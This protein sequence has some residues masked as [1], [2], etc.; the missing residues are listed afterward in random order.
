MKKTKEKTSKRV[1]IVVIV[2]V[3]LF[4][5]GIG[6]FIFF[7]F[8]NPLGDTR[9]SES[10][11]KQVAEITQIMK[12]CDECIDAF[13]KVPTKGGPEITSCGTF[14]T[15]YNWSLEC[16]TFFENKPRTVS[17]CGG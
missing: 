9:L 3:I 8:V 2:A 5:V 7:M 11:G 10:A 4:I 12:C 13:N 17:E 14:T 15:S 1:W 16:K 6:P